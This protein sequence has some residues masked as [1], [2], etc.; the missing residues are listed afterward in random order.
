[1][2]SYTKILIKVRFE[3]KKEAAQNLEQP[4]FIFIYKCSA[5]IL[6]SIDD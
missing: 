6:T 1:M 4:L 5:I 2:I 3:L